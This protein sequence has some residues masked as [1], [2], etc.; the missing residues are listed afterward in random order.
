MP[1][2]LI[3]SAEA[4]SALYAERLLEEIRKRNLELNVFGVGSREME[5]LGFETVGRSEEMA[6]VGFKEVIAHYPKIRKVFYEILRIAKE[7][8]PK[9][10]LL[11]DYPDFNLRLAKKLH[12]LGIPVVYYI[13]P[14]L[15]AWRKGRIKLVKKYVSKMLVVFPFEKDFYLREGVKVEFVGHP[16]LEELTANLFNPSDRMKARARY[17]ILDDELVLGLMPGSRKSE[18]KNHLSTQLGVAKKLGL[19]YSRL[20]VAL[21][22][23]PGLEREAIRKELRHDGAALI[24]IQ[25][26]PFEMLRMMDVVLVASGTATLTAGLMQIPMVI[27]YKMSPFSAWLA[28]KLVRS[29]KYFGMV[30]LILGKMVAQER[31]QNDANEAQLVSDLE[32]LLSDP[33]KRASVGEELSRLPQLLGDKGAAKRVVDSMREYF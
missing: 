15:W 25:A 23:A 29:T 1:S 28:K 27:M 16:L 11:L 20:K 6:V 9:V 22:V 7:R 10:A 21:L 13:S 5:R 26:P 12:A 8:K 32:V 4:S 33:L 31:F 3:V 14:Q 19:K 17:G 30:N 24:L 2:I 18:L